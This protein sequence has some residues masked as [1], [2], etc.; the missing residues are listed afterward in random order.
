MNLTEVAVVFVDPV[1][2]GWSEDVEVD[3]VFECFSGV[4][5][6]AWDDEDLSR[7][8]DVGCAVAHHEA[9]SAL[10]NEGELLVGMGVGRNNAAFAEDDARE[11]SLA[12]SN[13]L[14]YE[15]WVELLFFNFVPAVAS[16]GRHSGCLSKGE[17]CCVMWD[18]FLALCCA[19]PCVE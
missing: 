19:L 14:A 11:H 1:L 5:E 7:L 13:E 16:C 10:E 8:Y 18:E 9:E 6:V 4:S 3:R 12:T 15:E 17:C 2:A